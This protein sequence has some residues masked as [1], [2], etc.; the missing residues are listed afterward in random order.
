MVTDQSQ[1]PAPD[2]AFRQKVISDFEISQAKLLAYFKECD[3]LREA[4][5]RAG[6]TGVY[7][8]L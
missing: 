4:R 6:D 3:E 2:S 5:Y 8:E 7:D 1:P